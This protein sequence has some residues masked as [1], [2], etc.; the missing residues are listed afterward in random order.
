MKKALE[1]YLEISALSPTGLVWV[2]SPAHSVKAGSHAFT[3]VV[4]GYYQD[5]FQ[6]K[7]YKAHRVVYY[8]HHGK[9][10]DGEIDHIDGNRKNNLIANLRDATKSQNIQN[11]KNCKGFWFDKRHGKY[12]ARIRVPGEDRQEYLGWFDTAEEATD[13]YYRAKKELHPGYVENSP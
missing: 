1:D 12:L 2:R 4:N 13:A 5:G 6:G 8:L 3:N 7:Y 10:P 11:K 9:W